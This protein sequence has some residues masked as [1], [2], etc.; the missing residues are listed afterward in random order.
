MFPECALSAVAMWHGL[1][2]IKKVTSSG[3]VE[4]KNKIT[5]YSEPNRRRRSSFGPSA[6]EHL[7][8]GV[9]KQDVW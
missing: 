6:S 8:A 2:E 7:A 3:A 1:S 5:S 4:L 9:M